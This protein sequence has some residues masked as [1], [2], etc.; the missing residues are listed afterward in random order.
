MLQLEGYPTLAKITAVLDAYLCRTHGKFFGPEA[1]R[2]VL[3][4]KPYKDIHDHLWGTNRFSWREMVLLDSPLLQRLRNIHQ[5]GLAYYVYPC[6]RHS[7]FEHSIGVVTIASRVFD[8]IVQRH[9][10]KM[11]QIAAA[12]DGSCE[13]AEKIARL[14]QELRLAAL[15]HDTGHSLYSHA[16]ERVYGKLS[17]LKDAVRELERFSGREKGAGEVI[18]FCLS[19]TAAVQGLLERAKIRVM[20]PETAP[21]F[22]TDV[23]IDHVSLLII[24]RS[25][26]PSLQFMGDIISSGFD[27]D[28]LDYLLRDAIAAGLPLRYDVERYLTTVEL[29]VGWLSDPKGELEALYARAGTT[30]LARQPAPP[31]QAEFPYYDEA[32]FLRLPKRS[33]NTIEQITICKLML[34]SYIYHH[35][36][37]RAAE[38]FLGRLLTRVYGVWKANGMTEEQVLEKF[39]GFTDASLSGADFLE[40]ETADVSEMSY[41]LVNRLLPRVVY[42]FPTTA[43]GLERR[44]VRDFFSRLGD[45]ES[46]PAL[47][48]DLEREIGQELLRV[49]RKIASCPEDAIWKAGIWFDLPKTPEFEG[50]DELVGE[51][52][53]TLLTRIADILPIGKWTEAYQAHRYTARIYAFSEYVPQTATAAKLA[54]QRVTKITNEDYYRGCLRARA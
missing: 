41:R 32:V 25:K 50:M 19:Q 51:P 31:P 20:H 8:A 35:K 23:D 3:D 13:P 38:G 40:S 33:M 9:R 29:R 49:D 42:E 48:A 28:K 22:G 47:V 46:G 52:D 30:G 53:P 36:K 26:H 7:R 4:L 18:S 24:G 5:T 44:L 39:I 1:K 37:V 17:L 10:G 14:R 27:A 15:L 11:L 12:V 16:S 34:Y 54:M 43:S 45:E 2:P 21:E 6:A